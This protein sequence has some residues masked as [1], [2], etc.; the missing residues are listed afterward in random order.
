[1]VNNRVSFV[2]LVSIALPT[3]CPVVLLLPVT[4]IVIIIVAILIIVVVTMR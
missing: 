3:V 2:I 1:M 4:L